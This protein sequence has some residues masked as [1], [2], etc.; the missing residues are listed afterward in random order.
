M[1]KVEV[2]SHANEVRAAL[3]S[4]LET[5]AKMIGGSAEG[6]AKEACPVKTGNLRNSITNSFDEMD[7]T[8]H[9]ADGA[10]TI[11]V[12]T[13]VEYAPYVELGHRKRNGGFVQAKPFLRPAMENNR[14]EY[15]QIVNQV[16][17][18]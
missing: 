12:G 14:D 1:A 11:Y 15:E 6:H 10:V 4:A 2:T 17:G 8:G 16:L 18:R 13:S 3:R 7:E 5:A 9:P